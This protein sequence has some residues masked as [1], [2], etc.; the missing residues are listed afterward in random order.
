MQAYHAQSYLPI[1]QPERGGLTAP[2][3]K[4][5]QAL[6]RERIGVEQINRSLKI[7]KLLAGRYCNRRRLSD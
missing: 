3:R 4:Y 1:E 2:E 5:N 7:F 6:S